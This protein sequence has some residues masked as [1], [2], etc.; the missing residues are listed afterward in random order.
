MFPRSLRHAIR[1]IY[2]S[3]LYILSSVQEV[4]LSRHPKIYIYI[5]IL[6]SQRAVQLNREIRIPRLLHFWQI[7]ATKCYYIKRFWGIE[8]GRCVGLTNL[9]PPVSRL[10][11]QRGILN[12]SQLY[13]PPRPITEMALLYN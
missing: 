6:N 7:P 12:I 11:R 13:R 3:L 9:L 5:Y 8:R 2:C 4:K 1:V 10:S